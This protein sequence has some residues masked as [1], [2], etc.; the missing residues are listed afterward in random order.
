[1]AL[2]REERKLLHQKGSQPIV[3]RGTPDVNQG[4]NGDVSYRE[5]EGS[6]TVHYVKQNNQW[7]PTEK[8]EKA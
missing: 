3:G 8:D 1:M 5:I 2:N 6:G 4:N 7:V